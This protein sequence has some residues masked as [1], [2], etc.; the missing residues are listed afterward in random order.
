MSV[1]PAPFSAPLSVAKIIEGF[2]Q[3]AANNCASIAIIKAAI[4]RYGGARNVFAS[5]TERA[6]GALQAKLRDGTQVKIEPA[7]LAE[8]AEDAHF[9]VTNQR[10][11]A[12]ATLLYAVMV[13]VYATVELGGQSQSHLDQ[14]SKVLGMNGLLWKAAPRYLGLQDTIDVVFD[15]KVPQM[16]KVRGIVAEDRPHV[17]Q[18]A[19]HAWYAADGVHDSRGT[20]SSR[21][22]KWPSGVLRFKD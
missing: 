11:G 8:A 6:N 9:V 18:N 13:K 20:V 2:S 10:L 21:S 3:G 1:L 19:W 15:T 7:E 12:H 14:A 22:F 16:K 5:A 17:V 4:H